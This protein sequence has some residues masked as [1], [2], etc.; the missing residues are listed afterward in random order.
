MFFKNWKQ[1]NTLNCNISQTNCGMKLNSCIWL[2]IHRTNKFTY[3]FLMIMVWHVWAFPKL[4]Q[5][6]SQL[7]LKNELGLWNCFF[8]VVI[9]RS[10]KLIKSFQV[11]LVRHILSD[12]KYISP[13]WIVVYIKLFFACGYEYKNMFLDSV[14][15][16][17]CS[18]MWAILHIDPQYIKTELSYWFDL[19]G[20]WKLFE[21][22]QS[23]Q[24]V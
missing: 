21:L 23:L 19:I 17:G 6:L 9:Y 3:A 24:I 8:I 10:Y 11:D 12:S 18:A 22:I 5:V 1:H 14:H 20:F 16:Y 7:H 2:Y 13:E 4:C 15:S